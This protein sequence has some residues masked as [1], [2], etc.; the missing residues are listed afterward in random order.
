MLSALEIEK[1]SLE[2]FFCLAGC[3]VMS[4]NFPGS[5]N[6]SLA[7]VMSKEYTDMISNNLLQE[8]STEQILFPFEGRGIGVWRD[9]FNYHLSA[10]RQCIERAWGSFWRSLTC[11]MDKWSLVTMFAICLMKLLQF[12][13]LDSN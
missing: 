12:L 2:W 9:S 7:W 10:M 1:D 5:T 11:A 3:K 13:A 6:D 8:S 4:A